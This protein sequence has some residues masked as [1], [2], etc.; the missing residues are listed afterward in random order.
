MVET[1]TVA[2]IDRAAAVLRAQGGDSSALDVAFTPPKR[3]A[4]GVQ[5][6]VAA[7]GPTHHAGASVFQAV[8]ASSGL[9]AVADG[10]S[11]EVGAEALAIYTGTASVDSEPVQPPTGL[12]LVVRGA[13]QGGV[14][15]GADEFEVSRIEHD[16]KCRVK[17][18]SYW[19]R[20]LNTDMAFEKGMP[21]DYAL[22]SISTSLDPCM[23]CG[24]RRRVSGTHA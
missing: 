22:C 13:L 10:S 18:A 17:P 1:Y 2:D 6:R 20:T 11:V 3:F 12:S 16:K 14:D 15:L 7:A 23:H 24:E 8:P 19:T 21:C 9:L 4:R 5:R